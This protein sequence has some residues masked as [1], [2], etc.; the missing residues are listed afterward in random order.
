MEHKKDN[1]DFSTAAEATV[2][3]A[4]DI[5]FFELDIGDENVLY[6]DDTSSLLKM[7]SILFPGEESG[8]ARMIADPPQE[9]ELSSSKSAAAGSFVDIIAIDCEW[10]PEDYF[11]R[12]VNL[13]E[14]EKS[15]QEKAEE[16]TDSLTDANFSSKKSRR[17]KESKEPHT[18]AVSVLQLSTR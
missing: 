15:S 13:S 18:A 2:E 16:V 4:P 5:P 11:N 17:L 3:A 1:E 14:T 10:R 6:V 8:T 9:A 12:G 7:R